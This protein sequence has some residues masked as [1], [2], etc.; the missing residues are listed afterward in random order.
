MVC[1]SWFFNSGF[2]FQDFV[3]NG[4]HDLTTLCLN[5]IDIA[6]ITVK[7]DVY[8]CVIHDISKSEEIHLLENFVLDDRGYIK[9]ISMK[10]ILKI[11]YTTITLTI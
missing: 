7:G 1:R 4:Y 2:Q 11:E 10:S 9:S 6:I 3:C 8:C 5:I